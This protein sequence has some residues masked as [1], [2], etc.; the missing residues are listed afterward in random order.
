M[1]QGRNV[2]TMVLH[3]HLMGYFKAPAASRLSAVSA[4]C[5]AW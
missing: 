3:P 5:T 2:T 1:P 4:M